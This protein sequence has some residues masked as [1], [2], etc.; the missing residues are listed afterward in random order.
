MMKEI[1]IYINK[2]IIQYQEMES[3]LN[4]FE[5][6]RLKPLMPLIS[7]IISYHDNNN[8]NNE[9]NLAEFR[10]KVQ[11]THGH[12][13]ALIKDDFYENAPNNP[14]NLVGKEIETTRTVNS[15]GEVKHSWRVPK[16]EWDKYFNYYTAREPIYAV[17]R[18]L[19]SLNK[20]LTPTSTATP[21]YN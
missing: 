11:A 1:S 6:Q 10:Q 7:G 14:E 13:S 9:K 2:L 12:I 8:L 15:E 16:K 3:K 5:G 17:N 4:G 19:K 21:Q 18:I 20:Q